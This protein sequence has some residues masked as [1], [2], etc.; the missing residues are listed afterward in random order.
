[1]LCSNY[2]AQSMAYSIKV[3]EHNG[4]CL[5]RFK[6]PITGKQTSKTFGAFE[7]ATD[8][9]TADGVA[10]A[11]TKAVTS[12]NWTGDWEDYLPEDVK[13]R[14]KPLIEA[15]TAKW[16]D[17]KDC[18]EK[19]LVSQ[20]AKLPPFKS[21]TDVKRFLEGLKVKNGT[22][23]RYRA[24]IGA[25]RPDLVDGIGKYR[26][27]QKLPQPWEEHEKDAIIAYFRD[28]P[29]HEWVWISFRTGMR[30]GE[31]KALL[32]GD[33]V[34]NK[35]GYFIS[36]TKNLNENGLQDK[37]KNGKDRL[38][39]LPYEDWTKAC[40]AVTDWEDWHHKLDLNNFRDRQWRK[41]L[42][43][44]GYK[45]RRPYT[46]RHTAISEFLCNGGSYSVAAQFFG[47]S[48]TVIEKHYSGLIGSNGT[49]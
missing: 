10:I 12:G 35:K 47:T 43:S 45:Y 29:Y 34:K 32:P 25:V 38:V 9:H 30:P 19:S 18:V 17:R 44:L 15:L 26:E 1:M 37:P 31:T 3:R 49:L 27:A 24:A 5:I 13:V 20:L 11:I 2:V 28:T 33:F 6:C 46:T 42:K 14:N 40:M 39:P 7:D 22:K 21:P 16:G 23:N 4:R 8:K 48:G 41:A 36:V